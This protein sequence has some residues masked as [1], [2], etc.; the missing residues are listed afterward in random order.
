MVSG[1]SELRR[2]EF[3]A[4]IDIPGGIGDSEELRELAR[5]LRSGPVDSVAI[6]LSGYE[7][8]VDYR[9]VCASL[10]EILECD[11]VLVVSD[12]ATALVASVG[13]SPGICLTWG[14]GVV[15]LALDG[16]G[17]WWQSGGRGFLLG[18][19]GGGSWIGRQGIF[20]ALDHLDGKPG[21]EL[22]SRELKGTFGSLEELRPLLQSSP[23]PACI[24]ASFAPTVLD[25]AT[26]GDRSAARITQEAT[27]AIK[28][29]ID[30]LVGHFDPEQEFTVAL[31]GGIAVHGTLL[32]A[33]LQ[34]SL[35]QD[36]RYTN[37]TLEVFPDAPLDGAISIASHAF[38]PDLLPG[39]IY[40]WKR[41][42]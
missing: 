34:R 36:Q 3:R 20:D 4:G 38:D 27:A 42:P 13:S 16:A 31:T 2:F 7:V 33:D 30:A 23:S 40:T 21:S 37:A 17:S 35:D 11:T 41:T 39:L 8:I 26:K 6:S 10:A 9:D 5:S 18:D 22:L 25:A 15:A 14:T 28:S 32:V 19:V 1:T 12:A 24:F 29:E